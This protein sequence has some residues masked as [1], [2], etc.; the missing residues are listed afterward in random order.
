MEGAG[1]QNPT[2]FCQPKRESGEPDTGGHG[3]GFCIRTDP[4][5]TPR[6]GSAARPGRMFT[7]GAGREQRHRGEG[8]GPGAVGDKEGWGGLQGNSRRVGRR[9]DP[10]RIPGP[11]QEEALCDV[12]EDVLTLWTEEGLWGAGPGVWGSEWGHVTDVQPPPPAASYRQR[13]SK[14]RRREGGHLGLGSDACVGVCASCRPGRPSWPPTL[15]APSG[16]R[17]LCLPPAPPSSPYPLNP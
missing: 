2:P 3:G 12:R 16:H 1:P 13:G 4:P 5:G 10:S 8:R 14:T 17:L 15:R 6:P 9:W 7:E 11:Q